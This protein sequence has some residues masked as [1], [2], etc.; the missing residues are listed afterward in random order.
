MTKKFQVKKITRYQ[1]LYIIPLFLLLL[2]YPF[3]AKYNIV[4]NPLT[5]NPFHHTAKTLADI[6]L[7]VKA[8]ALPLIA[9]SMIIVFVCD[10]TMNARCHGL[11]APNYRKFIPLGIYAFFIA[12]STFFSTNKELSLS[13]FPGQYETMWILFIYLIICTFGYWYITTVEKKTTLIFLFAAAGLLIGIVF[14]LQFLGFDPYIALFAK[15]NATVAVAGVYGTFFN[16]NYAGSYIVLTL[17][18]L[19]TLL[20]DFRNQKVL[21]AVFGIT[22]LLYLLGLV[23]TRTTGGVIAF[24][25]VI[26]FALIFFLLKKIHISVKKFFLALGALAV[27]VCIGLTLYLSYA[28]QTGK[29]LYEPL[30]AIYTNDDNLEIH[31]NGHT[32]FLSVENTATTFILSCVDENGDIV[33]TFIKDESYVFEDE[34]FELFSIKPMIF[35]ELDNIVGFRL[36]YNYISWYFTN[37]TED[38]TFYH[39]TGSGLFTKTT[40]EMMSKG[41]LFNRIPKFM[42][43]RAYIWSRSIPLL[44]DTLLVGYGPDSFAAHF[45]NED[46]VSAFQGG[47][48]HTF[49]SKPHS[50]YL[51]IALQ[52]GVPS[53]LAFLAFYLIYF[54]QS[55]HLYLTADFKKQGTL[56][57]FGIFLGTFGYMVIGLINDSCIAVAPFFWLLLGIGFAVNQLNKDRL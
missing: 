13:G 22:I 44:K 4:N 30:E 9:I 23:G 17:P 2:V 31:R 38:G 20:A 54:V 52:T 42:S 10:L 40:P 48:S 34:R 25:A 51:Q 50:M 36:T 8:Q 19:A 33:E 15:H 28:G 3:L 55:V 26:T 35:S 7:Y 6:F 24:A 56:A 46:Y 14:V 47:F 11:T 53:L 32:L 57:S 43:G 45:P 39:I 37:N 18:I 21:S 1:F 49:I 12:L 5:D 41:V 29:Y 27:T 16:P